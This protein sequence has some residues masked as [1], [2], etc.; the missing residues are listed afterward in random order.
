MSVALNPLRQSSV[1]LFLRFTIYLPHHAICP[2][3]PHPEERRLRRVSK[4]ANVCGGSC[5]L[6]HEAARTNPD[7]MVETRAT[8]SFLSLPSLMGRVAGRRPVGWGCHLLSKL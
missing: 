5:H 7:L 1:T 6:Q 4:D 3:G 2:S 8:R